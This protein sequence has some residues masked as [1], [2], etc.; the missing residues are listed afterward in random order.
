MIL[1][2]FILGEDMFFVYIIQS[3]RTG[4]YYIGYTQNVEERLRQHNQGI[5]KPIRNRG[6][7]KVV[8]QELFDSESAAKKREL[9]IKRYKGG[10]AFKKLIEKKQMSCEVDKAGQHVTPPSTG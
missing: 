9:Q 8:Y 4:R 1:G 10:Y 7:F 6:P 5:T 2:F 3:L